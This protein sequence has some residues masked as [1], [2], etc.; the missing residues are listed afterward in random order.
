M[1][2][3]VPWLFSRQN[4]FARGQGVTGFPIHEGK[5]RPVAARLRSHDGWSSVDPDLSE[6]EIVEKVSSPSSLNSLYSGAVGTQCP[7][8][9]GRSGF[10]RNELGE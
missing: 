1:A 7:P 9:V 4:F 10:K 8:H 6:S 2:E 3:P 5:A